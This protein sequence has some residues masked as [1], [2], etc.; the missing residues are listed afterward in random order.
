M[1]E[2]K[3]FQGK[4]LDAAIADACAYY[5][6]PREK[7]EIDIV[8]DAKSGI[9]GIVGARK[10]QIRARRAVLPERGRKAEGEKTAENLAP[11]SAESRVQPDG[12]QADA[13][14]ES[15]ERSKGRRSRG[16]K[17][18]ARPARTDDAEPE[19]QAEGP[20]LQSARDGD[21]P[22]ETQA[23]AQ[24]DTQPEAR[25]EARQRRPKAAPQQETAEA[26]SRRARPP[27]GG[28]PRPERSEQGDA[29]AD[30]HE[31]AVP[32]VPLADLDQD[33]LRQV[34][35]DM[36][37]G[38]VRPIVGE[39]PVE[40]RVADE[41]VQVR[42]DC[43]DTGLLI[44]REGQNLAAV[45]YLAARMVSRA[46][47]A[48][49]RVQVDAGDYHSRQDSRLKDLAL[50][51]ADKVRATGKPMST[52]PLSAY[53]R[54]V[55]HMTLQEDPEVQTHSAG[56]GALKRVVIQRRKDAN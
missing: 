7:L 8:A 32:R 52:K 30:M 54:R 23:E 3:E 48:Q 14:A 35:A 28:A 33:K 22:A 27:R 1:S 15:G 29:D 46:M 40:V 12:A 10:A 21:A 4:T 34:S 39:A 50:G 25:D 51:L 11:E 42:I 5:D 18:D 6:A 20:D 44:G 38:L 26:Q 17:A 13:P 31:M 9:F 43:E 45:Q 53:Q 2:Y 55:I 19:A 16:R 56:E 47:G 41:R 37:L 24:P 36:V 49:V